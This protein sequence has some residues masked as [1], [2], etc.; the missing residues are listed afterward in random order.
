MLTN[1]YTQKPGQ[2]IEY[3]DNELN[4]VALG[5]LL[6]KTY[7][8]HRLFNGT[9]EHTYAVEKDVA[10]LRRTIERSFSQTL[11]TLTAQQ[12]SIFGALGGMTFLP[13]PPGSFMKLHSL[14][15]TVSMNIPEVSHV[16]L[17]YRDLLV[18]SDLDQDN[19]RVLYTWW[20]DFFARKTKV[21]AEPK[22]WYGIHDPTRP[23]APINTPTVYIKETTCDSAS[24]SDALGSADSKPSASSSSAAP[25]DAATGTEPTFAPHGFV[26]L[27]G[28][29]AAMLCLIKPE[30]IEDRSFYRSLY[31][32]VAP[33]LKESSLIMGK[34]LENSENEEF[35]YIYFNSMNLALKSTVKSRGTELSRETMSTLLDMHEYFVRSGTGIGEIIVKTASDSWII[36]KKAE[37]RL[38]F[39]LIDQ[40]NKTILDIADDIQA[41][42]SRAF[43]GVFIDTN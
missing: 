4:D 32:L 35:M 15:S 29:G 6:E 5:Q 31:D 19:T 34:S 42:C 3:L 33:T 11:S 1:S 20:C 18:W 10:V 38:L 12:A 30:A 28:F 25:S 40:R 37:S 2:A 8:Q 7:E 43:K 36:G 9:F 17:M 22:Y 24:A 14:V 23:D 41:L 27:Q 13:T 39:V 21:A 16:M 26:V